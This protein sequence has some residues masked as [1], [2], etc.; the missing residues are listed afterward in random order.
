MSSR[1]HEG[2]RCDVVR[3]ATARRRSP[4]P[5]ARWRPTGRHAR[6]GRLRLPAACR[7][8]RC[9]AEVVAAQER[10][11]P[12]ARPV[13]RVVLD[14]DRPVEHRLLLAVGL[15]PLVGVRPDALRVV[16]LAEPVARS[17]AGA[18][19]LVL[20][21]LR[22]GADV[23]DLGER[24]VAAVPAARTAAPWP[25]ARGRGARVPSSVGAALDASR[26]RAVRS[27]GAARR[28]RTPR[29]GARRLR[30]YVTGTRRSVRRCRLDSRYERAHDVGR[31]TRF[32]ILARRS[33]T[34]PGAGTGS[35]ARTAR[36]SS[37]AYAAASSMISPN[38]SAGMCP[39]R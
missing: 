27:E 16:D 10:V 7:L 32:R 2:G 36:Q 22:L 28:G 6:Q 13:E 37:G 1:R 23:R 3:R 19:A 17:A 21:A 11:R 33:G 15:E 9:N 24:A 31:E 34:P 5:G 12:R 39:P 38:V 30:R 4:F 35:R 14:D 20:R 18:V 8:A 29:R 26:R 25:P